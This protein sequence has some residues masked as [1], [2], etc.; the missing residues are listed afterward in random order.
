MTLATIELSNPDTYAEGM[1]YEAF[2][3]LRSEQPVSWRSESGGNDYWA[4]TRYQDVVTILRNPAEYSSWRGGS[5]ISDPSPAFLDKMREG[6]LHRDPP[7]HTALR[8]LVNKAFTP[9]RIMELEKR[10]AY[11]ATVLVDRVIDRGSCD[12]AR[13]IA[14][15]MPVFVICEILGVPIEDRLRLT[16]LTE[17]MLETPVTDRTASAQDTMAAVAEMRAYGAELGRQKRREPAND[18]VSELLHVENEGQKLTEGEF[19]ALF[20]L[21][22][23][24]GSDTTRSLLCFGLNLLLDHPDLLVRLREAPTLLPVAIEEMLR[25]ESPVI[26]FR[27]T[28]TTEVELGGCR[29]SEGEKVVV[30]FPSANRDEM[31]FSEPER[32]DISRSPNDH[33]SFGYGTHFC[34]G[35][36]LARVEARHVFQQVLGRLRGLERAGPLVTARSNFVRGVRHLEIKYLT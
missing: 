22:F 3:Q 28:A 4:V 18:L 2:K 13:D 21:L 17:R 16:S 26:Q 11:Y 15:E 27:R 19:E 23:N 32:F 33:L 14:A 1:P 35:A 7:A 25:Y 29:I 31:V 5:L 10:I 20:L 36:M 6:L 24:A 8:R 34:L 30:F 12:F 9:R